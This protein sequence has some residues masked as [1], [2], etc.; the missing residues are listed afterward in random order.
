MNDTDFKMEE[1]ISVIEETKDEKTENIERN[2]NI[3]RRVNENGEVNIANMTESEI[4]KYKQMTSSLSV[5][6]INSISSFGSELQNSMSEYSN[7]FLKAVKTSNSGEVGTLIDNLLTELSYIDIN[8][9]DETSKTKKLIRKIPI[10]RK[11]VKSVEKTMQKYE[12]I[13]GKVETI[14]KKITAMRMLALRDNNALQEMFNNNIQYINEIEQLIIAGKMKSAEIQRKI[15]EMTLQAD[16]Y[17]SHEISDVQIFKQ[18]LDR[19]IND[20]LTLRIVMKQSLPQIRTVQYNNLTIADKSQ[21]LITT[22]IPVWRNQ[23]SIAVAL[24]NQKNSIEAQKK[25][26][27]TTNK[28]LLKNAQVLK[29]NSIKVARE[30]ERSVVDAATL[31]ETTNKLIETLREVKNIHEEAEKNRKQTELDLEK[32]ESELNSVVTL[33]VKK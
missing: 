19:R 28:I 16:Q 31:R 12:G 29:E 22:T 5:N 24:N 33:G 14:S 18:N 25:I 13:S 2:T 11:L 7:N 27:D 21:S 26:S 30:N 15:D 9:F 1:M 32:I 8:D 20:L 6:D 23:I 3:I 17:A 4:A 10:L